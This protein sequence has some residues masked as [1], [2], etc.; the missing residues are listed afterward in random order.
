MFP[1]EEKDIFSRIN[2]TLEINLKDN[3]KA[4]I[5]TRA[6]AIPKS[7][8]REGKLINSQNAFMN[9]RNEIEQYDIKSK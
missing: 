2:E 7:R 4:R 5:L 3:V 6:G 8:V 1:V 9:F